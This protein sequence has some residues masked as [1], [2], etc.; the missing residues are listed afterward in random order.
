MRLTVLCEN[1]RVLTIYSNQPRKMTSFFSLTTGWAVVVERTEKGVLWSLWEMG[2]FF[3]KLHF[4]EMLDM[5]GKRF[6]QLFVKEKRTV[7]K[8]CRPTS[9]IYD[10]IQNIFNFFT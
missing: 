9:G 7:E 2:T 3:G 8:T 1:K 6:C 10:H 5:Y 4:F